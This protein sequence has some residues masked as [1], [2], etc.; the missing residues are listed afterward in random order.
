[1]K[2]KIIITDALVFFGRNLNQIALLCLPWLIAGALVEYLLALYQKTS[3]DAPVAFFSIFFELLFYPIYTASLIILMARQA[4]G[5]LPGNREIFTKAMKRW[6]P[7]LIL[8]LMESLLIGLGLFMFV[9][10]G[11]WFAVR[12]SFAE[13][14]LVLDDLTPIQAMQ[15]SFLTTRKHWPVI[16]VLLLIFMVPPAAMM[17]YLG[18]TLP[19]TSQGNAI[20]AISGTATSFYF[21]FVEILI[22]RVFMSAV[23]DTPDAPGSIMPNAQ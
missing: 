10:P 15:K 6:Q 3:G 7:L 16:L 22:F 17:F 14:F 2:L 12:L 20:I 9:L 8:R 5:E 11:L 19:D 21:L 18:W 4:Q 23:K 1:M 13:Y